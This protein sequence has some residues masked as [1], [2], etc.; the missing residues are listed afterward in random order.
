MSTGP[1]IPDG[2]HSVLIAE[3]D[4]GIL[5]SA[6]GKRSTDGSPKFHTFETREAATA[7]VDEVVREHSNIEC[8]VFDSNGRAIEERRDVERLLRERAALTAGSGGFLRRITA[9]WRK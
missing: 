6:P 7:F 3:I 8:I 9:R 1:K 4:T 2:H 5:L